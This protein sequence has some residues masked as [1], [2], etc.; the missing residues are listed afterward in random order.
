MPE[1]TT[2]REVRDRVMRFNHFSGSAV[3]K[4]KSLSFASCAL[5]GTDILTDGV[6]K[7]DYDA[8][9][10]LC[11]ATFDPEKNLC[12]VIHSIKHSPEERARAAWLLRQHTIARRRVR[13][14]RPP[15]A[16]CWRRA[17]LPPRSSSRSGG[18]CTT[19]EMTRLGFRQDLPPAL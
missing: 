17:L 5:A 13:G 2:D 14:C 16:T 3:E 8:P 1:R 19:A 9:F 11:R 6:K 4:K 10:T 7:F 12:V 18:C 15:P